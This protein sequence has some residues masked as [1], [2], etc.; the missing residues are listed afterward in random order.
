[1]KGQKMAAMSKLKTLI[2]LLVLTLAIS[3]SDD[4]MFEEFHSFKSLSWEEKDTVN[5]DLQALKKV[6]GKKLIGVR[7][8]EEYPFSNCY[9]RVIGKDTAGNVLDNR[10]IN[11]PLFDS[12]SGKPR[13]KGF[14][15]SFTTYDTLPFELSEQTRQLAFIQYMR[16]EH[17][18]GLEAVGLKILK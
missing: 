7:F 18:P 17:L 9:I 2:G 1:M 14:G 11:V 16:E 6:D 5:F 15:N 12:K 10:L 4:R 13:G 8:S 3:C